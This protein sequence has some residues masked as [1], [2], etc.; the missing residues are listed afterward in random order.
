MHD[1]GEACASVREG[2]PLTPSP[3]PA[4]CL[5]G[6]RGPETPH[7]HFAIDTLCQRKPLEHLA[8]ELIHLGCVL[9]LHLALEAI[10]LVHV[11]RLVVAW[12]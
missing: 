12:P 1:L 8:E 11:V 5:H 10:D 2:A 6:V 9:G 4:C 3:T 7:Q